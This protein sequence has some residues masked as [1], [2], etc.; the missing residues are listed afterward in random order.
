[1]EALNGFEPLIKLLQS[2]ALPLGYRAKHRF[3]ASFFVIKLMSDK[4]GFIKTLIYLTYLGICFDKL[5]AF[6][7]DERL[8]SILTPIP[9]CFNIDLVRQ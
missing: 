1:M 8:S 5:T 6:L 3:N 4:W 9:K 2:H 7:S